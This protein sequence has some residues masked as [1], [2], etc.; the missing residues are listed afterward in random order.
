MVDLS[1]P[2]RGIKQSTP[3][4][5]RTAMPRLPAN[6]RVDNIRP[7]LRWLERIG[8]SRA[9]AVYMLL[10]S[11]PD[12]WQISDLPNPDPT[13]YVDRQE[14]FY[15]YQATLAF[16]KAKFF[17]SPKD[18][19]SV[20]YQKF[21]A[22]EDRCRLVNT[23]HM[24]PSTRDGSVTQS[25]RRRIARVLGDFNPA[26]FIEKCGWGP[27]ATST[28][29]R[30]YA[31]PG[32]K[33]LEKGIGA[34]PSCLR[35]AKWVLSEDIHWMR[36]RI[37]AVDARCSPLTS[38]FRL[39]VGGKLKQVPKDARSNRMINCEPTMNL[40]LQKGIGSMI[41]SRLSRVGV[42]L[43]DQTV[44]RRLAQHGSFT[45]AV[46][47][48]DLSAASDSVAYAVVANLLPDDW[49]LVMNQLRCSSV[50]DDDGCK[51][52]LEK[53][54]MMGNGFT[55][56]LESL[57]FWAICKEAQRDDPFAVTS[58]F[59]DDIVCST[60]HAPRVIELLE[61]FGFSLNREKSFLYGSFRES[62]GGHYF[63]GHD[64]RPIYIE[65]DFDTV[66][67]ALVL[68]HKAFGRRFTSPES[69]IH[70][71]FSPL[72]VALRSSFQRAFGFAP[73]ELV[74][75]PIPGGDYA[76]LATG[77]PVAYMVAEYNPA[78]HEG[79]YIGVS[80][81]LDRGK[82]L[83]WDQDAAY[84]YTLRFNPLTPVSDGSR[85]GSH[86]RYVRARGLIVLD[87]PR[88]VRRPVAA[89]HAPSG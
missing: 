32:H 30:R 75:I 86:S 16:R 29:P 68:A 2:L 14:F 55:F 48:L 20:T 39:E 63:G 11:V 87:R 12:R 47:T 50:V 35:I 56:E 66:D 80:L 26:E 3:N 19:R 33:M 65:E 46:A 72:I 88:F 57:I 38:E 59:G 41:R 44:N 24:Q 53:F 15:D 54:S 73:E 84:A 4:R 28:I 17:D 82:V 81:R 22:S 1:K 74:A 7:V 52:K 76:F 62:C 27:G 45:G 78:G 67:G 64:V 58:V 8:T 5:K 70:S 31:T 43:N 10:R 21:I 18:L 83:T 13:H 23:Q 69:Y 37:D 79:S 60:E 34:T 36:S 61:F 25:I 77:F 89:P 6:A 42:D 9:L 85:G 51:L 40:F 49:F 71:V